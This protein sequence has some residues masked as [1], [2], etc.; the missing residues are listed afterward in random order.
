M[1]TFFFVS[2]QHD[3]TGGI[4]TLWPKQLQIP[5]YIHVDL[6]CLSLILAFT[7]IIYVDRNKWLNGLKWQVNIMNFK[8]LFLD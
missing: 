1:R 5:L 7:L 8:Y 3:Y 4:S 2:P 6:H